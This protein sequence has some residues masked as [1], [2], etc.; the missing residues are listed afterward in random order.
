MP[1]KHSV[2]IGVVLTV[3]VT[4]IF[5]TTDLDLRL[6][7]LAYSPVAPHWPYIDR[8][9]W[10][11]L[12]DAGT[13]PGLLF[14]VGATILLGA[15]FRS[16]R[17]APMRYR[18]AY[19]F[20][21]MALGPGLVTNL[22][23]KELCGRPRPL[24]IVQFGGSFPFHR[25]FD[26]GTPGR[27]FSFLCGH[28]SMGFLFFA[29]F[30]LWRGWKRWAALAFAIAF[31]LLIGA[32]RVAQAAHFP[33]DVLLDGTIMFTLA[34]LLGPVADLTPDVEKR[35]TRPQIV[36]ATGVTLV[37][38]VGAFLFSTPVRKEYTYTWLANPRGRKAATR[39]QL[40]RW[41][42]PSTIVVTVQKGDIVVDVAPLR[43]PLHIE[44]VVTG[45]G[46]PGADADTTISQR[47]G[48]LTFTERLHG[49][50]WESHGSYTVLVDERTH[51]RVI[52][53]T[54]DGNVVRRQRPGGFPPN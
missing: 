16:A 13:L 24:E 19:V 6:Q 4:I 10:R 36:A 2:V 34:A 8:Q 43:D 49:Y 50:Y 7:S 31:G 32:G 20:L 42:A 15:S 23:G 33:S 38:L 51:A 54:G 52:A 35:W 30:F 1:I 17:F 12:H 26:L 53:R 18:F 47:N 11:L 44:G 37:L 39:E 9:P 28:C 3:I 27:G 46:F 5:R 45:Y 29:L 14:A 21:L 25:P 22:I 40:Y 48:T 41:T